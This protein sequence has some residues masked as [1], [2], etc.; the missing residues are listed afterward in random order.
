MEAVSPINN[1]SG[2]LGWF[3]INTPRQ[4]TDA[5]PFLCR[6]PPPPPF[7]FLYQGTMVP[8]WSSAVAFPV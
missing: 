8:D 1:L 2:D 6:P 5:S 7:F 4:R 3:C